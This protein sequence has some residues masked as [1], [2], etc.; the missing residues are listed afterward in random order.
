MNDDQTVAPM[1]TGMPGGKP[2]RHSGGMPSGNPGG[3]TPGMLP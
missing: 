2:P 3:M 1:P